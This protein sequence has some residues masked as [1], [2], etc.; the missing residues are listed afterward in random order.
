MNDK[1]RIAKLEKAITELTESQ[2]LA[3]NRFHLLVDFL[4][5]RLVPSRLTHCYYEKK[6]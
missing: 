1:E 4:G 2:T 6:E 5:V 3:W